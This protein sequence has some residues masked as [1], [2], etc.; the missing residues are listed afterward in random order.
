MKGS[1]R[2]VKNK[3]KACVLGQRNSVCE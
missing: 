2:C 1:V 3:N